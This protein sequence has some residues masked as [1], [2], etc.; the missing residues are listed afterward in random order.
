MPCP[1]APLTGPLAGFSCFAHTHEGYE[2]AV[3]GV[4]DPR[5]PP[6]LV[7]HELPGLAGATLNFARR[8]GDAGFCVYLPHLFGDLLRD[9]WRGNYQRLCISEEFARLAAGVSAPVTR[10]L[11]S[12]AR[13]VSEDHGGATV[14]AVGMC[15]TG[16]FVI[17]L[18]LERPVEAPVAAQPA[19]PFSQA[20]AVLPLRKGP[21]ARQLNVSDDDIRAAA[22]RMAREGLRMLAFR[23]RADRICVA[24]KIARLGD[25]FGAQLEAH[26]YESPWRLKPPHAVLTYE[27]DEAR[28][29]GPDHPTRRAFARLVSFLHERLDGGATP[30]RAP[31]V[32]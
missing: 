19:V 24:D 7:M 12:L 31:R 8:L 14:G 21:W 30:N 18:V 13:R 16:G 23:F 20:Y 3:Y 17:P 6:V 2:H 28:D 4:G 1:D 29:A 27:Y 25:E 5:H 10:W 11:R 32:G 9:D 26:E 15:L 22:G